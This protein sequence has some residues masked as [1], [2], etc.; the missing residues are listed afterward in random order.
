MWTSSALQCTCARP[1][2]RRAATR[3]PSPSAPLRHATGE[4]PPAKQIERLTA[5]LSRLVLHGGIPEAYRPIVWYELSGEFVSHDALR[6]SPSRHPTPLSPTLPSLQGRMPRRACTRPDTTPPFSMPLL[7]PRPRTPLVKTSIG[8]FR[9]SRADPLLA[10]VGDE[11]SAGERLRVPRR[12]EP[13]S[14]ACARAPALRRCPRSSPLPPPERAGPRFAPRATPVLTSLFR[15]IPP[16]YS[17]RTPIFRLAC[18]SGVA[19]K[20]AQCV[21]SAQPRDRVLPEHQLCGG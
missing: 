8:R 17:H 3:L 16:L 19:P 20:A 21:C 6:S 2:P 15:H 4:L 7:R 12:Q 11:W 13:C 5:T 1:P 10:C 14:P 9:V 18:G